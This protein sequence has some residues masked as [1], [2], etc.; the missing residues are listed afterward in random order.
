MRAKLDNV[1]VAEK[2]VKVPEEREVSLTALLATVKLKL[3]NLDGEP[4]GGLELVMESA[5]YKVSARSNERGAIRLERIP[6]SGL[7]GVGA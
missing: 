5:G 1:T 3:V 4:V 2:L 6:Y 7:E